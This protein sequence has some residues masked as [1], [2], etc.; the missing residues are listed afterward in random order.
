MS[1]PP[2]SRPS[3]LPPG[4]KPYDWAL[5]Q[6]R[7]E[8]AHKTT[9]GSKD[10]VVAV[11]DL[12]YAHHPDMDGHLW[13]NPNPTRGDV[14]GWDCADDDTSLEYS[15]SYVP[16]HNYWHGHRCR[17]AGCNYWYRNGCQ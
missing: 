3:D 15:G 16:N 9:R 2:N 11:V 13:Q 1:A 6:L 8:A 7:V 10:V 5:A 12:G 17:L 4:V 14:H